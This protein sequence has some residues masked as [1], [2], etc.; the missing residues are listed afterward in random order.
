MIDLPKSDGALE[1]E[2]DVVTFI[3]RAERYGITVDEQGHS[4]E[5]IAEII[6]GKQRNGPVGT[7]ELA[8][9]KQCA[10]FEPL[11]Q[12]DESGSDEDSGG[13]FEDDAPF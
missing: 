10:R 11:T 12:Y 4:T 8:F 5:G 9:V 6:I 1:N 7:V 3:Y 2:A 13:S